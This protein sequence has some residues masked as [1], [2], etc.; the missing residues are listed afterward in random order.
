[1]YDMVETARTFAD[2]RDPLTRGRITRAALAVVDAEGLEALTMRR[3]AAELRVAPMSAYAHVAGKRELLAEVVDAVLGEVEL[4]EIDGRW[5]KPLRRLAGSLRAALL[6]HPAVMPAVHVSG[7]R[8]PNALSIID[9]A[10]GILRGAGFP[11]EQAVPAVDTIH[12]FVLGSASLEIAWASLDPAS[13]HA[14]SFALPQSA[15][16]D[17]AAVMPQVV[18]S[19]GDD[20][21]RAGLDRI[22]DGIA[23]V[24]RST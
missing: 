22:L 14:Q 21:F 18:A 5:R 2:G 10:H 7:G 11:D 1:M 13:R 24:R 4:P 23:V 8:G 9:R 16:P 20:R 6:A 12:A 15:Y 17:L 3:L 19:S